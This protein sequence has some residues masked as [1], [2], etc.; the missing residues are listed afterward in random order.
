MSDKLDEFNDLLIKTLEEKDE[1]GR[2]RAL[3]EDLENLSNIEEI[4]I[5]LFRTI[6]LVG[7]EHKRKNSHSNIV[8]N[9]SKDDNALDTQNDTKIRTKKSIPLKM[10]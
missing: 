5:N 9:L 2:I 7:L 6:V 3:K 8:P 4:I 10:N 1:S